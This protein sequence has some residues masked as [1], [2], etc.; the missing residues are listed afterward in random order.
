MPSDPPKKRGRPSRLDAPGVREKLRELA[1]R[2]DVLTPEIMARL[3]ELIR[4]GNYS[5]VA[6]ASLGIPKVTYYRWREDNEDFRDAISKAEGEAE[7]IALAEL[8]GPEPTYAP[9][10]YL[11]RKHPDRWG[12][13][14]AI[15][16]DAEN[17]ELEKQRLKAEIAL[18]EAKKL[19][20]DRG[21]AT[22]PITVMLPSLAVSPGSNGSN[23]S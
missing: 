20:S 15:V 22:Q 5:E 10:W 18:L 1:A 16:A 3:I 2:V 4:A 6:A 13:R 14:A 8:R 12:K 19:E 21:E 17:R 7:V 9:G 23:G 11:E